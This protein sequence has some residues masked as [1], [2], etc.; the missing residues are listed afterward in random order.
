MRRR[1]DAALGAQ[2]IRFLEARIRLVPPSTIELS[3]PLHEATLPVETKR[4]Q[5]PI[6]KRSGRIL[7]VDDDLVSRH[8]LS[9]FINRLGLECVALATGHE[10]LE[11]LERDTDFDMAIVDIFLPDISGLETGRRIRMDLGL[12]IPMLALSARIIGGE[13]AACEEA[14]FDDF[15]SKPMTYARVAEAIQRLVRLDSPAG[16]A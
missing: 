5:W 10:I 9:F 15:L 16:S 11:L 3:L 12:Q 1:L 4:R 14:G 6:E 8:L 13:R 7:V 2:L